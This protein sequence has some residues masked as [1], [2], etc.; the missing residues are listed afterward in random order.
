MDSTG[1]DMQP[2]EGASPGWIAFFILFM[3]IANVLLLNL[4]VAYVV[5]AYIQRIPNTMVDDRDLFLHPSP[6]YED[7]WVNMF[8]EG[9][10]KEEANLD[11]S[12]QLIRKWME[13]RPPE[14]SMSVFGKLRALARLTAEN[15][16]FD[17]IML[18]VVLA[19]TIVLSI[20]F[21]GASDKFAEGLNAANYVFG[22]LY[23][24]EFGVRLF[25]EGSKYFSESSNCFDAAIVIGTDIGMVVQTVFHSRTAAVVS[26]GRVAR[27]VKITRMLKIPQ[28]QRLVSSVIRMIP[29]VVD[30]GIVVAYFLFVYS[31]IGVQVFS[32]VAYHNEYNEYANFRSF[33]TALLTMFIFATPSHWDKV[34]MTLSLGLHPIVVLALQPAC[35]SF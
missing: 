20:S 10:E 19:N 27:M 4:F 5:H 12:K 14:L 6:V 31:V 26:L 8:A 13:L 18:G 22:L 33:Q 7:N 16:W 32:T 34:V 21:F 24:V 17:R 23:N 25:A 1:V 11:A 2:I 30:V 29:A 35:P 9:G 3:V 15:V 28:L